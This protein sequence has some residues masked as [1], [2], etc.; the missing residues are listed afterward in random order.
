MRAAFVVSASILALCTALLTPVGAGSVQAADR[1]A[2]TEV[3]GEIIIG[4]EPSLSAA[5]RDSVLARVGA[6]ET[7]ARE[8]RWLS[9]VAARLAKVDPSRVQSV[10]ERLESDP[11]VRYAEP[12]YLVSADATPNDPSFSQL[13]G[14]HNTGQS[15]NGASGTAD[16]DIDA[17]EAWDVATG[18]SSV[19]VGVIDT[20][21]D[22]SHPDLGGSQS[23]SP[24]MWRNPGE[25][26]GGKETNGLDDDGNGYVDDWR[27]WD[28]VDDDNNPFDDHGHGTHVAGTIG[29]LG[30][31]GIGV[32]G[33]NWNVRIMPLKFLDWF[34]S[35]STADAVSAVLYA[36]SKG[37]H[38][39]NNSWGGVEFSQ[40][41]YDAIAQSDVAGSLFVAAA[42]NDGVN[43][44][45]TPHYPSSYDLP[46]V[47]SVA[48]SDAV[49]CS[50]VV[51]ERRSA[52]RRPRGAGHER[53]LD[54]PRRR[55]T[56]GSAERP[57]RRRTSRAWRHLPRAA[58]RA[59]ARSA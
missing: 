50:R 21:V 38:V 42:G 27:G 54:R 55:A 34:G 44:D 36:K 43:N 31:N 46:N 23:T 35:G 25:S 17:P 7:S 33:V 37:A 19:V 4:F 24:L 49:G 3:P 48:A 11:R 18:S 39:T 30:S 58:S 2:P 29:G 59:R 9:K 41:L 22:F 52:E 8:N 26:G 47:I 32:T 5:E 6:A 1:K 45:A 16:A 12:N 20:G 15:V 51:L 14:L 13:W 28:F 57:W 40:A 10:L 56:T 53:V